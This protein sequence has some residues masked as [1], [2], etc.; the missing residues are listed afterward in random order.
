LY[1]RAVARLQLQLGETVIDV[2]CG[3]GLAFALV[4]ERIG[5]QGRLIGIE[6]S[7]EMLAR[8]QQRVEE[9]R[10]QNVTLIHSSAQDATV[11][12]LADA[13]LL[14]LTHD[15]MRSSIALNN[16]LSAVRPGGRIVAAGSK[17]AP[18]WLLPLNA[19]IWPKA[20]R[21]ITT[22]EGFE[23]P[24]SLLADLL[25]DVRVEPILAGAGYV[26]SATRPT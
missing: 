13:A 1:P 10:W 3:T 4:E 20:R 23:E 24:W 8:A 15:I 25:P 2:G 19:Y 18:R 6:Q 22:F 7:S 11:P 9:Q 17:W 14:I 26:A 21:Y 5:P 12:A 16:I